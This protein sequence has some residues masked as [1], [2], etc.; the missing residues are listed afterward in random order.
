MSDDA[1]AKK[2]LAEKKITFRSLKG[3][4]KSAGDLYGVTG[5]P[6]NFVVDQQGRILFTHFGFTGPEEIDQIGNE[7]DAVLSR[8]GAT[9]AAARGSE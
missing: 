3:D 5:T 1:N 7:V 6:S 2:F 8:P 4:W 9:Q